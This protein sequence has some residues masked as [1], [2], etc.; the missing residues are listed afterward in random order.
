MVRQLP[1]PLWAKLSSREA[2][3]EQPGD[4]EQDA[5]LKLSLQAQLPKVQLTSLAAVTGVVGSLKP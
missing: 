5:R 1:L 3:T 2:P 4:G